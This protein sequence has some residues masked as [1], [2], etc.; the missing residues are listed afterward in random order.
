MFVALLL[1]T[2]SVEHSAAQDV[3]AL[4]LRSDASNVW[5]EGTSSRS[6]WTVYA[7]EVEGS[8]ALTDEGGQTGVD[9]VQVRI[10]SAQLESR[11]S[12]I[13]DRL[14]RDALM[15]SDH[16]MIEFEMAEPVI[17]QAGD[18]GTISFDTRGSLTLAGQTDQVVMTVTGTRLEDGS[19]RFTGSH[20]I[21][22]TDYG[23]TPPT[24]MFGALRT[25]DD[26]VVHF[27]V[28]TEPAP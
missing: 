11:K 26:V 25:G 8:V 3:D 15:A 13:M 6:D 9:R 21:K 27:D 20:P 17:G 12:T 2:V 28:Q 5:V 10:P 23:I 22:M 18:G 19:M 16:P 14:M 7:T 4:D 1:T 24:A